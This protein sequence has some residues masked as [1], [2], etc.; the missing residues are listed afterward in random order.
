MVGAWTYNSDG[1]AV[2]SGGRVTDTFIR[3]NDDSIKLF[4]SSVY[5][6]GAFVPPPPSPPPPP[7]PPPPP[8]S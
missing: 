8:V 3:A 1:I 7:P 5:M 4:I 2:G 6:A